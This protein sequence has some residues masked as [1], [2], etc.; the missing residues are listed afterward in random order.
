MPTTGI[1]GRFIHPMLLASAENLPKG[2]TWVYD[3][4]LDGY[5]AEAIRSG[6]RVCL[7][8]RNDKDFNSRF[9]ALVQALSA[10]RLSMVRS[11]SWTGR[12]GH[13]STLSR[14]TTAQFQRWSITY[15]MS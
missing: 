7:R 6:G 5:R 13:H 3:L 10:R 12:A 14:T 9:P 15:S 11:L 1:K 2:G 4:K 8:S